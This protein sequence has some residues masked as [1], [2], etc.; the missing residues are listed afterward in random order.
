MWDRCVDYLQD[1]LPA[2]QF[3]TWIRPLKVEQAEGGIRLLAPNR[4]IRD[5]VSDKFMSRIVELTKMLSEGD[6]PSVAII[7]Q[8]RSPE[9]S[10]QGF[11]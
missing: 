3:N 10:R 4:F 7:V 11:A 1:E 9:A 5:W 6:S 2:Q 8:E